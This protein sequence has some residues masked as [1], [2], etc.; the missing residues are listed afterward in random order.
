MLF[1]ASLV[2]RCVVAMLLDSPITS[3]PTPVGQLRPRSADSTALDKH[4]EVRPLR[5][6]SVPHKDESNQH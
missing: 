4:K 3:T 1:Y 6:Y 5:H 2:A